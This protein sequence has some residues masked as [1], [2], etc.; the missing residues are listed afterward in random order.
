MRNRTLFLTATAALAAAAP[1]PA[2]QHQPPTAANTMTAMHCGGGMAMMRGPDTPQHQMR[3]MRADSMGTGMMGTSMME[4]MGPPGP[5]A[6][7][8]YKAQLNLTAAQVT[9]LEALKKDAETACTEHMRL[10]MTAHQAAN[11][12][13]EAAAPDFAAYSAKLTEAAGHMVEGQVAM[14]RAAVAA[15][16]VLTPSQRQALTHQLGSM[17]KGMGSMHKNP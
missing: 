4:M 1:L 10:G 14:A 7:L 6:I 13:L 15:R 11:Q 8:R 2:Q 3:R 12:L 9:R 16:D 5:A 17:H